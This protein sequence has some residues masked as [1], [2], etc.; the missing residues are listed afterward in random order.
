M[1]NLQAWRCIYSINSKYDHSLHI[2]K[3]S[4][5]INSVCSNLNNITDIMYY[6]FSKL[7]QNCLEFKV[8]FIESKICNLGSIY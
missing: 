6:W 5:N 8:E 3:E 4:T 2:T 7:D 1:P